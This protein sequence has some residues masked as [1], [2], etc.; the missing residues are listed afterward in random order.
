M[1]YLLDTVTLCEPAKRKP[2][3]GVMAWLETVDQRDLFVSALTLGEIR[4]GAE[5]RR[6]RDPAAAVKYAQWLDLQ[7]KAFA[8]RTLPVDGEVAERW[9]ALDAIR[10]LPIIDGLLAAT[11]LVRGLTLVTRN[12]R[13]FAD[14][15]V[16]L[17]N[18][19]RGRH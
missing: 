12:L 14:T 6:R 13:D 1:A 19:W 5:L 2:D 8:V 7:R 18:P 16:G 3:A 17:L 9:G 11:A 10:T 4:R 15:G